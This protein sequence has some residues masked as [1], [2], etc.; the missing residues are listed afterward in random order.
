MGI[1]RQ[2]CLV[3]LLASFLCC[4]GVARADD[5]V[6]V[7]G[8]VDLEWR[9]MG[10]ADHVSHGPA[11]AAGV[12][13]LDGALRLGIG[14]LSRPGPLN[15]QT[16]DVRLPA[17]TTYRGE[18]VLSLRSDGSMVGLHLG[19]AFE[20]PGVSWLALSIPVTVGYGGYGFYLNGADRETPDG[21]RVST[22]ENTLLEGR[23]AF[24]GVVIDGG[25]RVH[26][27]LPEATW[28]RPYLGVYYT[29]VPGFDTIVRGDY[30]GVSGA[31]G[32][33]IGEGL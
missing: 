25:V 13:F 16:F 8:F 27:V 24:I 5:A 21:A 15:P 33:E 23:D 31:L 7:G 14:G 30:H 18:E 3:A 4:A 6:P 17:G 11:F 2:L 28:I 9:V 32:V 26:I 22:W 10:Q 20:M 1:D 12:T 19:V 29:G